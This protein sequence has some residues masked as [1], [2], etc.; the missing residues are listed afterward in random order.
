[1]I[2]G[3]KYHIMQNQEKCSFGL[4]VVFMY[5]CF[6]FHFFSRILILIYCFFL[7]VMYCFFYRQWDVNET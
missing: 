1:M 5:C 4:V 2:W 7:G 3:K 6:F